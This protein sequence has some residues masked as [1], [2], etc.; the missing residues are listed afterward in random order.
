MLLGGLNKGEAAF[1]RIADDGDRSSLD[2]ISGANV[3]SVETRSATLD[4]ATIGE[5]KVQ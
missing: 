2:W 4:L 3:L 5:L 1:A